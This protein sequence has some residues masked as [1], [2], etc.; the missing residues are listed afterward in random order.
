MNYHLGIFGR[1][2]LQIIS[3]RMFARC[4]K[5]VYF[6]IKHQGEQNL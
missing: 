6:E 5:A 4:K 2:D 1:K 3:D